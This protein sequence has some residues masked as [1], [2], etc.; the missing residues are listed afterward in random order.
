[1]KSFYREH[2]GENGG[3]QNISIKYFRLKITTTTT[4]Q[5]QQTKAISCHIHMFSQD[6][7]KE[8]GPY[9]SP[10]T[11]CDGNKRWLRPEW[12]VRRMARELYPADG[13]LMQTD[14]QAWPPFYI[15]RGSECKSYFKSLSRG[16]QAFQ[17]D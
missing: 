12:M 10:A 1:M 6:L 14:S 8:F 13:Y 11:P 15:K 4:T 7:F 16:I 3:L 2:S 9:N 17:A 5:Q